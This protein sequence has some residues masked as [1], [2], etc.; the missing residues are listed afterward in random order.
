M[1]MVFGLDLIRV[2]PV[3]RRQ[4]TLRSLQHPDQWKV[5]TYLEPTLT[6]CVS[7]QVLV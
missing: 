1:A 3:K 7:T 5:S 6:L 2:I 4:R